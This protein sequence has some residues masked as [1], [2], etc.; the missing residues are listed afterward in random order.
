[1][2]NEGDLMVDRESMVNEGFLMV[3]WWLFDDQDE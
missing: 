2:M 1:M 3:S